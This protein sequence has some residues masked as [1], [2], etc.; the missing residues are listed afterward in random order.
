MRMIE[1]AHT[2]TLRALPAIGG[3]GLMTGLARPAAAAGLP[4]LDVA[5]F[6]PQLIWLA[7]SFAVLYLMMSKVALPRISQ[8][9]EERQHR[10]EDNMKKAAALQGEAEA[11][12][13]AYEKAMETARN[14]AHGVMLRAN[15][16]IAQETAKRLEELSARLD[17]ET[18]AA[19]QEIAKAK[20]NAMID[21]G[22]MSGEIV[23]LAADKLAGETLDEKEVAAAVGA[24]ME[25]RR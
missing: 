9:L 25:G 23:I 19:E 8:V 4:Q 2:L 15:E 5:T 14:E 16:Q 1:I 12:A 17:G 7:I 18:R 22:R 13:Q 6:P 21:L 10:I 24:V 11:A 3:L 20:E